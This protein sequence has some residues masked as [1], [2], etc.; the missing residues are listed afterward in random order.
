M[1][2]LALDISGKATGWA[3]GDA[4]APP[5]T[6]IIKARGDSRGRTGLALMA[7]LRDVLVTERPGLVV[8][9]APLLMANR[10]AAAATAHMLIGLAMCA[11]VACAARDVKC[12]SVSIQTWRKEFLGTGR[13]DDPKAASIAMCQS[14]GWEV[15]GDDN[16]ADACGVWAWGHIHRGEQ[17]AVMK[18]LAAG[19]IMVRR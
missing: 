4:T 16:R 9:E 18:L 13:P 14:L 17:K 10:A 1:K 19:G 2:I 11:E 12:E 3:V 5:R 8:Y 6:G 7:A 15:Q